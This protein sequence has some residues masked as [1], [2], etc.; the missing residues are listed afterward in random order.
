MKAELACC[1]L[2]MIEFSAAEILP[3]VVEKKRAVLVGYPHS[4]L[5]CRVPLRFRLGT[6]SLGLG[7]C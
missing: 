5:C 1:L 4:L 6:D 3:Q 2:S 7:Q